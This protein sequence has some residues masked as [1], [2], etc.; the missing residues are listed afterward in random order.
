MQLRELVQRIN[1]G[2]WDKT[3][4]MLYPSKDIANQ[5]SRI[6]KLADE[7]LEIYGNMDVSLFSVPG[8]TELSGNHT[9]HNNGRALAASVDIDIIAIAAKIDTLAVKIKS[10]HY[11]EDIIDISSPSKDNVRKG[12]SSAIIKGIADYF[13]KNGYKVGG[14]CT[15]TASDIMTGSGLSSSAAFEV[16]C[17]YIMSEFYNNG[18]VP[19]IELAKAGKYAENEYFGKPCGLMDQVACSSG[20][21]LWID[22]ENGENPKIKKI[23][24]DLT[25]YGYSLCIINAGGNHA[26][27]AEDYASIPAEMHSIATLM[28]KTTLRAC[29]ESDFINRIR[30]LRSLVSDR[31]ILRALHY[32]GENRRVD[33]QK[34]ALEHDDFNTYLE[35][36]KQSGDSSFKLLQNIY[37]KSNVN[38][39]G[40][41]LA[42]A[43]TERFGAICRVHG[44]GFAGTIQAYVKTADVTN[45]KNTIE[46]VFGDGSCKICSIRPYGAVL[47]NENEIKS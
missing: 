40:L 11:R 14:F 30:Y 2:Y 3:I 37:S 20:G 34:D 15:C 24:F 41:A 43:V 27:F 12:S 33:M 45:Y 6:L 23:D 21:C 38:T 10:A 13:N 46:A 18:E 29:D 5:K 16:M 19:A 26:H 28:G 42:L 9:D 22:F 17:A 32:F 8:R 47:I 25:N 1:S 39:Q 36:V 31:A 44:G 35:M 7:F 4:K